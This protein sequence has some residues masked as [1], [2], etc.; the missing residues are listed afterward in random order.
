[1]VES[2]GLFRP[3]QAFPLQHWAVIWWV[4]QAQVPPHTHSDHWHHLPHELFYLHGRLILP[5][6]YNRIAI[7]PVTL[8]S[9]RKFWLR[10]D[11]ALRP[12]NLMMSPTDGSGGSLLGILPCTLTILYLLRLLTKRHSKLENGWL[13][14]GLGFLNDCHVSG[15]KHPWLL[16]KLSESCVVD[17][18]M[19]LNLLSR[20]F[21]LRWASIF[22]YMEVLL[23]K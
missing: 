15:L 5:A 12:Y 4:P 19:F 10:L 22:S 8:R 14:T 3:Q 7:S 18:R 21:S 11:F 6:S 20:T 13:L 16:T 23:L 1:M 17:C 2:V 9:S